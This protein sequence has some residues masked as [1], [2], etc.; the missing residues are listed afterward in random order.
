[1]ASTDVLRK[2]LLHQLAVGKAHRQ[3]EDALGG[4]GVQTKD[5]RG[6]RGG[7]HQGP[8][9]DLVARLSSHQRTG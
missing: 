6:I 8:S 2:D 7:R 4:H 3:L 5:T 1:M 9:R